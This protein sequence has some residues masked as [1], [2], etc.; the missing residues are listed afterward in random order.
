MAPPNLA[1]NV[2][3]EADINLAILALSTS[4]I[5]TKRRAATTF[6]VSRATLHRRRA[7]KPAR[8]DC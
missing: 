8:R 4:Q 7:G 5:Q 6:E 3:R 2:S 1:Q